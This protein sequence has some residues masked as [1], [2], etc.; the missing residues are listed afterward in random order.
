MTD[1]RKNIDRCDLTMFYSLCGMVWFIPI[2]A[3]LVEWMFGI[4]LIAFLIKR[5]LSYRLELA[6]MEQPPS[7][8]KD[9]LYFA[10]KYLKPVDNILNKPLL[11]FVVAAVLSAIFGIRPS[12][13][14]QSI[15]FKVLQNIFTSFF[16]I[17]VV[18]SRKRLKIFLW[19]F[20]ASVLLINING[21]FQS[22]VGQDFIRNRTLIDGRIV[23]S[24]RH[25]NDFAAYL[26]IVIP[27]LFSLSVIQFLNSRIKRDAFLEQED[28]SGVFGSGY[29]VG[30]MFILLIISAISLGLTFSRGGWLACGISLFFLVYK[31]PRS[32]MLYL[33]CGALFLGIFVVKMVHERETNIGGSYRNVF[34]NTSDRANNWREAMTVVKERPLFG[35]GLNNYTRITFLRNFHRTEYPHNCYLQIAVEMGLIGLISFS[36]V[37][38]VLFKEGLDRLK[39]LKERLNYHLLLGA[40][41][42]LGG[43]LIQSFFD[44]NF[45][46][47][48]LSSLMWLTV[49][50]IVTIPKIELRN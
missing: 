45:Y 43:F 42:G 32:L 36:W 30:A 11:I 16:F 24:F 23:S 37:F 48:Q 7:T 21:V 34:F 25:P 33:V 31:R 14:F 8:F 29:F 41:V 49:G 10:L 28:Q 26:T 22:L 47:T 50:L 18:T 9:S 5:S 38:W 1:H 35:V 13:S 19:I 27:V 6:G 20:L 3:A 46:S 15:V 39:Q 4:C 2:S 12:V 44:T 40:M 17:E